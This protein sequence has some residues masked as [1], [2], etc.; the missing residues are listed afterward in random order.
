MEEART[1][2]SYLFAS[3]LGLSTKNE[4]VQNHE[5]LVKIVHEVNLLDVVEVV[6]KYFYEE[7]YQLKIDQLVLAHVDAHREEKPGV[8]AVHKL[9]RSILQTKGGGGLSRHANQVQSF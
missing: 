8:L 2:S 1:F 3:L 4:L 9:V 6:I 7:V 5:N